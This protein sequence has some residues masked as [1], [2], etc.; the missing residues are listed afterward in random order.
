MPLAMA[1]SALWRFFLSPRAGRA[2]PL[3]LPNRSAPELGAHPELG[4]G[5]CL[6]EIM[7]LLVPVYEWSEGFLPSVFCVSVPRSELVGP[8]VCVDSPRTA[9]PC[10][11]AVFRHA[12]SAIYPIGG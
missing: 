8:K 9:W 2:E 6:L 7:L 3:M 12:Q 4:R 11:G 10:V 1:T 5:L